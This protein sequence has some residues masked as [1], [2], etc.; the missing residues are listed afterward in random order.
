MINGISTASLYPLKTEESLLFLCEENV[1]VTEIFFNSH[2]EL[3]PDFVKMLKHTAE[4][5]GTKINSVHPCGSVGE[6]YFLFSEYD[7]RTDEALDFYKR[8][9]EA[10]AML[11]A[12][13]VV[14]HG[15]S[16]RGSLCMERYCERLLIMNETAQKHGVIISHENVNRF[17]ASTPENITEIRRLTNDRIS[18]TFD[19]KQSLR[20]GYDPADVYEAMRGKIVNVHISDNAQNHDCMLPGRGNYDFGSLFSALCRDKY[21]GAC[22]IEVYRNSYNTEEKLLDSLNFV[23]N[24]HKMC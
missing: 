13:S 7:R 9:Y 16:V 8:Y 17:R 5:F 1:P 15:D 22:L 11:G 20:A 10:A 6:P 12:Y 21:K 19:V 23:N 3:K 4:S 18:F 2:E 14:L 24:I